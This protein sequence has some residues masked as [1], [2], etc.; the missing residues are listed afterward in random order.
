MVFSS[1]A[2]GWKDIAKK[3][4]KLDSNILI[5]VFWHGSLSQVLDKYGW[6]RNKEIIELNRIGIVDGFGTCK[7]SLF[8][9]YKEQGLNVYFVTNTVNCDYNESKKDKTNKL[10]VGIYAAKC[11]DW[12]KNIYTEIASLSLIN[13]IVLDIVPLDEEVE[14]VLK[15]FNVEATGESKPVSREELIKRMAKNNVNL[16]V[17]YSECAPMLPLESLEVGVPCITGNNHHYFANTKLE[18]MLVIN[19]ES[20]IDEIKDKILYA[21]DNTKNILSEYKKFKIQNN[22]NKEIELNEFLGDDN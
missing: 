12:R 9:F 1:F 3:V 19:N 14:K 18:E 22:K 11:S 21:V 17:T 2:L 16:Y 15:M 20:S 7:E 8:N 13:N 5:N 6:E 10:K 4:K